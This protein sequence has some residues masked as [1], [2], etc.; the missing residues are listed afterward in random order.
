M[1][2]ERNAFKLGLAMIVI[3]AVFVAVLVFMAPKATG[4]MVIHVRFPHDALATE[5]KEGGPVVCGGQKVGS[6]SGREITYGPP[7][8]QGVEPLYVIVTAKVPADLRLK[9]DVRI[10]PASEIL[11]G[12]GRLVIRH[13]GSGHLLKAGATVEGEPV[14]SIAMLTDMLAEQLDPENPDSLMTMIRGLLDREDGR[15][16]VSKIM[17][18]MDDINAVTQSLR[19]EMD[20]KQQAAL[21]ARLHS[22]LNNINLATGLLR[23]ELSTEIDE[24]LAAKMHAI[25]DTLNNGLDT[26]VAMLQENREPIHETVLHVRS[27]S[28]ILETQI[29]A[30]LAAQLDPADGAAL[31][32]RVHVAMD[33]LNQSLADINTITREGKEMVLIN[34]E[35]INRMVENFKQTS[36]HLKAAAKDIRRNP[37]RLF[38]QPTLAEAEQANVFDSARELSLAATQLDDAIVRI[39]AIAQ[40]DSDSFKGDQEKLQSIRDRLQ[41]TFDHFKNAEQALWEQLKIEAP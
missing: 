36:D 13:V 33:R 2:D 22:I 6:I 37:W 25:L 23:D 9:E 41:R 10:A 27:T 26:A 40:A 38:Y 5:L 31:I 28:E 11:G 14:G 1:P 29:A 39:Q 24:T 20:A 15:S 8:D 18:S 32:T 34:E 3:L 16:L 21:L 30:R 19:N 35:S 12:G 7:D 4:D 17:V